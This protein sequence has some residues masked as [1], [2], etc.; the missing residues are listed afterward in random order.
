MP[1]S[2]PAPVIVVPGITAT[3]LEDEYALPPQTVWSVLTTRFARLALH[4][5]HINKAAEAP[6]GAERDR[7]DRIFETRQPSRVT[8]GQIYEIAYRELIAELR[9]G[10]TEKRDR[11][12]PV[13]PFSYDWRQPLALIEAEL[14]EFIDE[15]IERTKLL[16]HYHADGYAADPK[17]NIVGHSM[18]GLITAGCLSTLGSSARVDKVATL[19]TPYQ[20]S[21]EAVIKVITGTAD[22][23]TS[24]PSSRERETARLTPALYHLIPSFPKHLPASDTWDGPTKL[25]DPKAWQ[26]SVVDTISDYIRIHGINRQA[27]KAQAARAFAH[28]LTEAERH[29]RRVDRFKLESAGLTAQDWLCVVG[30]G[31]T[32]RVKLTITKRKGS[33]EFVLSSKDRMNEWSARPQPGQD[34]TLTGD[35][36]VP[37]RGAA[38]RFLSENT[39]VCVPPDDFGYWELAD[40]AL[41]RLAGFHGILPNMDMLHRM[42]IRHLTGK[43]DRHNNTWGWAA[44][45]V[46]QS[47]W[48]PPLALIGKR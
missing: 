38:P 19:A 31:A 47:D 32:T 24:P 34:P 22:L 26:P 30:V 37:F 12:V 13:Y 8:P 21:F 43:P 46:V 10:L 40:K 25:F 41:P 14:E 36:T 15:V 33:A 7:P 2:L 17:V 23:G 39:L 48:E 44:P 42:I 28:L 20:G 35:G 11:P 18:G 5:D 16:R 45:G 4:P 1:S 29:R 6:K 9:H 27:R 3:Y